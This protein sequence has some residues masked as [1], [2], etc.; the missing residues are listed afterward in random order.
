MRYK[1][2]DPNKLTT[3]ESRHKNNVEK[4]NKNP[5]YCIRCNKKIEHRSTRKVYRTRKLQ[6]CSRSCGRF[7]MHEKNPRP[8]ALNETTT[9]GE[10]LKSRKNYNSYRAYISKHANEVFKLHNYKEIK[11]AVCGYDKY[12][13]VAHIKSVSSFSEDTLIYEI[14]DI[15]NLIGLC[16]NC[17][18]EYDN[19]LLVLKNSEVEQ[20]P[21]R[22]THN[23]EVIGSNPI[24][25]TTLNN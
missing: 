5:N 18:W 20:R 4:Y 16:P 9:K 25:A 14:N 17:H 1:K 24:F 22:Q 10:L 6:Y 11:C 13:D 19:G 8:F 2:D 3:G 15:K 7:H 12:V 23:L 21:A